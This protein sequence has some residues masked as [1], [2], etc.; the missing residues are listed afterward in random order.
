MPL[1]QIHSPILAILR[2]AEK[3]PEIANLIVP[4]LKDL[5]KSERHFGPS[6]HV[7]GH[8]SKEGLQRHYNA[9][10]EEIHRR[11]TDIAKLEDKLARVHSND[12]ELKEWKRD[13]SNYCGG[14]G[15]IKSEM[16]VQYRKIMKEKYPESDE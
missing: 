5:E 16:T 10:T 7:G 8:G 11:Q 1:I 13:I 4:C 2:A 12:P 14:L 6:F 3:K 15:L 9:M